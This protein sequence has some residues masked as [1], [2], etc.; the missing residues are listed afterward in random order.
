MFTY[1]TVFAKT[2]HF[3]HLFIY[4]PY[5]KPGEIVL[6]V[7]FGVFCL[8]CIGLVIFGVTQHTEP[9]LMM[10]CWNANGE[11]E[12]DTACGDEASEIRWDRVPLV[13]DSEVEDEALNSA[14]STFNSQVGCE[15]LRLST[16]SVVPNVTVNT[17]SV[18]DVGSPDVIGGMTSFTRY[19]NGTVSAEVNVAAVTNSYLRQRVL[20]H[21][22]GHVF[23]L[24]HDNF[25]SSVMFPVQS[26]D[27]LGTGS[28]TM[29]FI[30]LTDFD[31]S[32]L[33][34]LYCN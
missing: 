4:F 11:A 22:F 32:L 21:E 2:E 9:G 10:V 8:L 12:F 29:D 13:V 33:A 14:V 30:R 18:F 20:V 26:F 5:M 27:E 15:M 24:A 28:G 17:D 6:A 25:E 1:L 3:Q 31:R 23:G 16:G 19:A 7:F 34:R